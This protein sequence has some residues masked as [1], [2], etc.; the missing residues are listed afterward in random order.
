[1]KNI[2]KSLKN[3]P[4]FTL[5]DEIYR[6]LK[7]GI[8]KGDLKR[9]E[10]FSIDQIAREI[11]VSRTPVREA[12]LKLEQ[13]GFVQKLPYGG[14]IVSHFSKKDIVEIF[15]I[16]S[17]LEGYAVSLAVPNMDEAKIVKLE[18]TVVASEHCLAEGNIN[19][20]S[21]MN[22]MFHDLI[23]QWSRSRRLYQFIQDLRDHIAIYRLAI[24]K[25]EGKAEISIS[26]HKKILRAIKKGDPEQSR[27]TMEDHIH[28]GL[29]IIL[30]GLDNK[31]VKD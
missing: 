26:D 13:E 17:V 19:K 5:R 30:K 29:E 21:K 6:S 10:K 15:G 24:L 9:G 22:E 14:F 12:T 27:A 25:A 4:V 18:N 20:L 3:R 31:G 7:Q 23:N 2:F 11:G 28:K 1:V 16:R 8:I